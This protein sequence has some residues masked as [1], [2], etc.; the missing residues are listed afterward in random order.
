MDASGALDT[1]GASFGGGAIGKSSSID[2]SGTKG[3]TGTPQL[4]LGGTLG[5][6]AGVGRFQP[7]NGLLLRN[8]DSCDKVR[9]T[10]EA[11]AR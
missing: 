8:G 7:E 2:A 9:G 6:G 3:G 11:V 5:F 4:G 1:A 10:G